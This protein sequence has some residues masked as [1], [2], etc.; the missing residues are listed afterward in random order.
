ML[1]RSYYLARNK[2]FMAE[3]K[4]QGGFGGRGG[5][6]GFNR[7]GGH[8]NFGNRPRFGGSRERGERPEMF[9]A[10]CA[11]CGKTCEVPFRPTGEKPVYCNDCFRNNKGAQNDNYNSRENGSRNNGETRERQLDELKKQF[12]QLNLKLD[13][14]VSLLSHSNSST[15]LKT[16]VEEVLTTPIKKEKKVAKKKVIA[17][18][19]I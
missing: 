8:S 19:K 13:K 2:K 7:G 3:Y 1:I 17:K 10:I 15:S 9:Q 6:S 18:K 11:S 14:I 4:R 5:K 16:M 12:E